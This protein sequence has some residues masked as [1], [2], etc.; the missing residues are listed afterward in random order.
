VQVQETAPFGCSLD[1]LDGSAVGRLISN[2]AT[3]SLWALIAIAWLA[4]AAAQVTGL[5]SVM[6]HGALI[7]S[8]PP[9]PIAAAVSTIGWLVMTVG[10]MLPASMRA[11][12]SYA[13]NFRFERSRLSPIAGFIAAYLSVWAVFGLLSFLGDSVVHRTVDGS[14]WLTQHAYL[15]AAAVL[16]TA[17]IYQFLPLKDRCL[18]ACRSPLTASH[19]GSSPVA[20][21][22]AHA[23]DCILSSGPLMLLMFAAGIA[24]LWWMAAI[25]ALMVY[26]T[27]GRHGQT[28][29][30]A[31]GVVLIMTA[32]LAITTPGV[33]GILAD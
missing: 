4:M 13:S 18:A 20:A 23:I 10:M 6:H 3:R 16:G 17:G 26:E 29:A 32:L 25:T 1:I 21:G 5:G 24:N 28:V 14:P 31:A 12:G 9:L 11:I 19:R 15:I 30:R 33:A 2:P 7:E 27:V 8:G 22:S